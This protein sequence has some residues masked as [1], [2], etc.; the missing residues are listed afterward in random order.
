MRKLSKKS[1][2]NKKLVQKVVKI[3]VKVK[4]EWVALA[5]NSSL[6][7]LITRVLMISLIS[8]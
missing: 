6:K 5:A 7:V 4:E 8:I 3:G 2:D 1:K